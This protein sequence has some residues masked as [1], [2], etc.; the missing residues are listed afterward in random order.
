MTSVLR[1]RGWSN[2]RLRIFEQCR[3]R[4]KLAFVDRVPEGYSETRTEIINR[5]IDR[6]KNIEDY[7]RG[8]AELHPELKSLAPE[9]EALRAAFAQGIVEL[10][11]EWG[12]D[13]NWNPVAWKVA[14]CRIK[15]DA[16]VRTSL[17]TA[18]LIDYKTGKRVGNEIKHGDQAQLYCVGAFLRYPELET[19]TVE[20]WYP[21]VNLIVPM[22][23]TRHQAL[24]MLPSFERRAKALLE[25]TDFRPNPNVWSCRYCPYSVKSGNGKCGFG[26]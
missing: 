16:F 20:L 14:E 12:F 26:I 2:H 8:K 24:K 7:L 5:G 18:T 4:A 6:H 17:Q 23:V 15:S 22:T 3:F 11:S 1:I 21:D 19:I 13:H 9:F 25:C 10:E